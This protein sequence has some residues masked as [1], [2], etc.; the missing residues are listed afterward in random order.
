MRLSRSARKLIESSRTYLLVL[1]LLL[2]VCF[3][4]Y[5]MLTS[6]LK[7]AP[8]IVRVPPVWL[9][10]VP[11][12]EHYRELFAVTDFGR[13]FLNSLIVCS[14]STLIAVLLGVL[15]SYSLARL[16]VRGKEMLARSTLLAYMFPGVLLV[17][18]LVL[19]FTRL[20]LLNTQIGL[21]LAY[22]TFALPFVMWVMRDFLGSVPVD[23]EEAAMIDGASR[24][25]ALRDVVI[26]QAYPGIIACGIFAFLFA[27]NEYLFAAVLVRKH[28]LM[29]LPPAMANFASTMDTR[30][31]LVMAAS[32]LATVP[33]A[34]AFAF[35]QKYLVT[36]IGAGGVKG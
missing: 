11:T 6:S 29:T 17:I 16:K 3:P 4:L 5:W 23:L 27:W 2:P 7:P 12:L 28:D 24:L 14:L 33:M 18:P 30:W 34:L 20:G 10:I 21:S 36:G 1:L 22:L 15:G 26:P 13:W 9:P 25:E 8:E 35:L 19:V 31:G 32:T